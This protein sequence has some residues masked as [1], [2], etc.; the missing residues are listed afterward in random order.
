MGGLGCDNMTAVLVCLLNEQS[1]EELAEKCSTPVRPEI[2]EK[3]N[4][5]HG[6]DTAVFT[7]PSTDQQEDSKLNGEGDEQTQPPNE[8]EEQESGQMDEEEIDL[9]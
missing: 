7:P 6:S 4:N 2:L 8:N 5:E 3:Y 9:T 1:Y